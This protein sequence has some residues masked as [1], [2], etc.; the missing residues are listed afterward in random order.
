M[1]EIDRQ[2][3]LSPVVIGSFVGALV[4]GAAFIAIE[5]R[6]EH[7]M[8]DLTLFR[9]RPFS[10]GLATPLFAYMA[11]FAVTFTMPFYLLSVRGLGPAAAGLIL[12]A[13]PLAMA[14]FAPA[15]GRLSDRWGSRG[16]AT[17]G[18][19][20]MAVSLGAMSFIATGT[21]YWIV[22]AMLF[23]VGVGA[24]VFMTP[25]TAAV[26][27]ATPGHRVGVGSALIGQARSVGMALGIGI[28]A[29]VVGTGL[30]GSDLMSLTGTL[31][32]A[33]AELF[34]DAIAP[35]LAVAAGLALLA[36]AISWSRGP[37][38]APPQV[39]GDGTLS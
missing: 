16:L 4:F 25:N 38:G 33:Q 35:A 34:V 2:G 1:S 30:A 10:A 24:A 22:A 12:T 27:R 14:V 8:V 26:L 31:D 15:S 28:T 17:V 37:D 20:W 9:S 3:I 23:S 19:V 18:L 6:V 39:E 21:P 7:P 11:L 13:T 32:E 5:R 29:A 36:S